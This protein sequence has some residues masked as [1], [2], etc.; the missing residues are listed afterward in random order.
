VTALSEIP[1]ARLTQMIRAVRTH[2]ARAVLRCDWGR[3]ERL[4]LDAVVLERHYLTLLTA[5]GE[6]R[7]PCAVRLWH[8][9]AMATEMGQRRRGEPV[10]LPPISPWSV[11]GRERG[12]VD[13][14]AA[15]ARAR[16]RGSRLGRPR[17]VRAASTTEGPP[18][19][20]PSEPQGEPSA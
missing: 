4:Y 11:E 1:R 15:M 7:E 8:V 17:K 3:A 10:T 20:P 16:E 14:K 2:A 19:L 6:A 18:P 12:G 5:P 13:R 9:E